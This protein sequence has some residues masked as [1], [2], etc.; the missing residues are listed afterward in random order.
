MGLAWKCV[1][2]NLQRLSNAENTA[3]AVTWKNKSI[4][5]S[6]QTHTQ[7]YTLMSLKEYLSLICC[8]FFIANMSIPVT[9]LSLLTDWKFSCL[10][11]NWSRAAKW[12][13]SFLTEE[14]QFIHHI[15]LLNEHVVRNCVGFWTFVIGG[16]DQ[17]KFQRVSSCTLGTRNH[18]CPLCNTSFW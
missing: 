14:Q 1:P 7:T 4:H 16:G 9:I 8:H 15:T 17:M 5:L 13:S 10:A 12:S 2:F 11:K 3:A 18:L 6:V